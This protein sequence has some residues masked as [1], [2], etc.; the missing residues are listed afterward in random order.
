MVRTSIR[1]AISGGG[2][3]FGLLEMAAE[4]VGEGGVPEIAAG[5]FLRGVRSWLGGRDSQSRRKRII[6]K[7]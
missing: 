1:S 5:H 7:R 2:L 4:N 3:A 6:E